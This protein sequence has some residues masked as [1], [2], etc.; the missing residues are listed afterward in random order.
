MLLLSSL[1]LFVVFL[2]SVVIVIVLSVV[3]VLVVPVALEFVICVFGEQSG[4]TGT[5]QTCRFQALFGV[6]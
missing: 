4:T 2:P 1:L 3:V 5:R 6:I